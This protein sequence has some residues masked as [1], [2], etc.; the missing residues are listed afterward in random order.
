[1]DNLLFPAYRQVKVRAPWFVVGVPRSGT[2]FLHRLLAGDEKRFTTLSL[3]E[4]VFAPSIVQRIVA[5]ALRRVDR[6]VGAPFARL[7][8]VLERRLLSGLD[9]VHKTGM[10]EPEEDYLALTPVLANLLLVLPFGDPAF[11]RLARFDVTL[12]G[13]ER[14]RVMAFYRRLVQRHL[15]V[16]GETRTFLSK[17]PSF[18]PMISSLSATFPDARFI[19]CV[20]TPEEAVPSQISSLLVGARLFSGRV[21]VGWW[22]RHCVDM[23]QF[24][25]RY[26]EERSAV[27]PP[28]RF[29]FVRMEALAAAPSQQVSGLYA[30]FGDRVSHAFADFLDLSDQRAQSYRSA[31]RYSLLEVGLDAQQLAEHFSPASRFLGYSLQREVERDLL[32]D[33]LGT[34]I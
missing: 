7:L 8:S 32:Q 22:S 6:A 25:Y 34:V 2:T 16:H 12:P 5:I 30:R 23:L 17:N 28:G 9:A 21:G 26:L 19:A 20:R 29:A 14:E 31:H 13:H 10:Q 18:T 1:M 24:Y 4:I 3:A 33:R 15:Y 11:F 27:L